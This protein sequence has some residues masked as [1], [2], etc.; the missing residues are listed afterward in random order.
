MLYIRYKYAT[1]IIEL[2]ADKAEA[3]LGR[4]SLRLA[5]IHSLRRA[6]L[7]YT[8]VILNRYS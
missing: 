4:S 7:T 6:F 8:R 2:M 3:G 5:Y 1:Y